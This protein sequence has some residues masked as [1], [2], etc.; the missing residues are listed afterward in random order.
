MGTFTKSFGSCGGYIAGSK[1]CFM[2]YF[3]LPKRDLYKWISQRPF[4]ARFNQYLRLLFRICF[5]ILLIYLEKRPPYFCYTGTPTRHQSLWLA[6]E[7]SEVSVSSTHPSSPKKSLFFSCYDIDSPSWIQPLCFAR[8][9]VAYIRNSPIP[10][11]EGFTLELWWF[12]LSVN[13]C[14][15]LW[16]KFFCGVWGLCSRLPSNWLFCLKPSGSPRT[17]LQCDMGFAVWLLLWFILC[18]D[19]SVGVLCH[20]SEASFEQGHLSKIVCGHWRVHLF[21]FNSTICYYTVKLMNI[22]C[23]MI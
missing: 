13:S 2:C 21:Q 5:L 14:H 22:R 12:L 11:L 15:E 1:V 7:F 17:E 6:L 3:L 8:G 19:F 23:G 18:L 10:D 20:W 9:K 16:L 4:S